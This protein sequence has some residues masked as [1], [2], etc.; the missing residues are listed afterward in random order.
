MEVGH[1]FERR[2]GREAADSTS[3]VIFLFD[4]QEQ[5]WPCA[6]HCAPKGAGQNGFF[7]SS[8]DR[9]KF[10]DSFYADDK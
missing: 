3:Y 5:T 7:L 9:L 10:F 6:L 4:V 8:F 1:G 2:E